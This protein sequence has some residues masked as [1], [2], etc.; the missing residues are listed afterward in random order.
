[1]RSVV[2]D[3]RVEDRARAMRMTPAQ[4]VA[5]AFALWDRDL[6]TFCNANGLRRDEARRILERRRQAGRVRSRCIEEIIG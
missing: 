4:R 3:L 2:D 5:V 6:E 1:M